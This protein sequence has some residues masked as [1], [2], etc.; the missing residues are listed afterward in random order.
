[1]VCKHLGWIRSGNVRT[2]GG[3]GRE[4]TGE[5]KKG[6]MVVIVKDREV[7]ENDSRDRKLKVLD[8]DRC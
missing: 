5:E 6:E 7:K 2:E 4:K 3:E 1:M 8:E